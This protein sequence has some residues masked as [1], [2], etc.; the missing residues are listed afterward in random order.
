MVKVNRSVVSFHSDFFWK[1]ARG[2]QL[3]KIDPATMSQSV[4]RP[5]A[6]TE[7]R[8]SPESVRARIEDDLTLFA[9]A[10]IDELALQ[11]F[12][13]QLSDPGDLSDTD[14]DFNEDSDGSDEMVEDNPAPGWM[15]VR[16]AENGYRLPTEENLAGPILEGLEIEPT[17]LSN[18]QKTVM[19]RFSKYLVEH[20]PTEERNA[21]LALGRRMAFADATTFWNLFHE[22]F[23]KFLDFLA[24]Q[25]PG[26]LSPRVRF[27]MFLLKNCG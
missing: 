20:W 19:K 2:L 17:P 5:R 26:N 21:D 11:L 1:M 23:P 22:E 6:D 24:A 16:S 13:G 3:D 9:P 14:V 15:G 10:E 8:L 12:E 25:P 27:L 4:K 18:N 7:T